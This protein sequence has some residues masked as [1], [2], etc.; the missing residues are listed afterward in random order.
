NANTKNAVTALNAFFNLVGNV[1]SLRSLFANEHT[2]H[3]C[4]VERFVNHLL[5]CGVS[6]FLGFL[7]QR[8]ISKPCDSRAL[9][10]VAVTNNI[11]AP[12]IDI[13][14]T[15]KYM[16]CHFYSPRLFVQ[17]NPTSVRTVSRMPY[18]GQTM[19]MATCVTI[20]LRLRTCSAC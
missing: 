2:C 17:L 3:S 8:T 15:E 19:R 18:R 12:N 11:N 6:L 5:D 20:K 14:K 13:V 10:Y 7:P 16:S 1:L 9:N 4:A